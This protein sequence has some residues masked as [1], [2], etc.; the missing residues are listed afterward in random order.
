[1]DSE[2]AATL[3][4]IYTNEIDNTYIAWTGSGTSGTASTFLN[5]NTNYVRIDGP[6]VWIE[7]VCQNGVVF[8]GIHYHSVWRDHLRDY[9]SN[10]TATSL[11]GNAEVTMTKPYLKVYPNPAADNLTID[12]GVSAENVAIQIVDMNGKLIIQKTNLSGSL[13]DLDVSSVSKGNYVLKVVADSK[14]AT[15]KFIKK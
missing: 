9:G 8:S 12:L 15:A 13:I 6:S 5:T 14:L 10:L 11:L 4:S 3:L 7:F 2:S 1:M